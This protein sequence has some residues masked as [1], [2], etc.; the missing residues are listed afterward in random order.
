MRP[1]LCFIALLCSAI[2]VTETSEDGADYLNINS[3][4][5]ET[6]PALAPKGHLDP[7]TRFYADLGKHLNLFI[8]PVL[9]L[10]GGLGNLI[11]IV[12]LMRKNAT[13][14]T[15]LYFCVMAIFDTL[16]LFT[17]LLRIWLHQLVDYD[18]RLSSTLS[19]KLH[20][21]LTYTFMQTSSFI[22]VAITYNRFAIMFNRDWRCR[23]RISQKQDNPSGVLWTTGLIL[24]LT[25]IFN[26]HF[27]YF[28]DIEQESRSG[29]L[30]CTVNRLSEPSYYSF[31]VNYYSK[32][33]LYLFIVVPSLILFVLNI[34]IIRKIRTASQ[35]SRASSASAASRKKKEKRTALSIMLIS[36]CF[37]FMVL[38]TPASVYLTF[39]AGE[40]KKF[41]FAFTYTLFM[42]V[43]YTNHAVNIILYLSISSTFRNEFKEFFVECWHRLPC[44]KRPTPQP[45]HEALPLARQV[46]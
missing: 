9:L 18:I 17:G 30:D 3:T 33:H 12:V 29:R 11:S 4:I 19:C 1:V 43:N 14:S 38:K 39:P 24:S 41:Y 2:T 16:V 15:V 25:G 34:L 31:R 6:S 21:F 37:W 26:A 10:L 45:A 20:V 28:Y 35:S 40:T 22:L 44:V 13:S 42:L 23:E 36:V 32:L 46:P 5:N 7:R 8:S 27:L